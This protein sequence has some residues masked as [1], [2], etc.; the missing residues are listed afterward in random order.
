MK[1][2]TLRLLGKQIRI[3]WKEMPFGGFCKCI[4][5]FHTSL[6]IRSK[7]SKRILLCRRTLQPLIIPHIQHICS[8]RLWDNL[9]KVMERLCKWMLYNW[10]NLKGLYD[11]M[12]N[13]YTN[14]EK[15]LHAIYSL[16]LNAVLCVCLNDFFTSLTSIS[17]ISRQSVS[18]EISIVCIVIMKI[19]KTIEAWTIE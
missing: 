6:C 10:K 2:S 17:V 11:Y 3:R 13:E 5:G 4:L 1:H 16:S 14:H 19:E 18:P 15:I 7:R 8:R 12:K 9:N